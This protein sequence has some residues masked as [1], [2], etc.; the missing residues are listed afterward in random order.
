M[1]EIPALMRE[2]AIERLLFHSEADFQH[3]LAWCIHDKYP[4][5]GVRLEYKPPI[6]TGEEKMQLEIWLARLGIAIELKYK[7]AKP[8]KEIVHNGESFD[9]R[10]QR[11]HD[12]G[13]Y[14][15]LKDIERLEGLSGFPQAK[16]GFAILLTNDDLYWRGPIRKGTFDAQFN[17]SG[18]PDLKI[19]RVT[20]WD[21]DTSAGTMGKR[22]YPIVLK[23]SYEAEW[24]DY[25][26]VTSERYGQFRYLM[27]RAA[28]G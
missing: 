22:R 20:A 24:R 13:R 11:A 5:S 7:T 17:L 12:H 21:K 1:I 10:D 14:D 18:D 8:K 3:A 4:G 23:K 19:N 26:C 2:L 9:L 16:A 15:F 6:N 28:I 25:R 27:V